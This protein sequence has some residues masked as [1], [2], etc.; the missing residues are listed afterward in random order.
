MLGSLFNT[1]DELNFAVY[2]KGEVV[3]GNAFS[4]GAEGAE[5]WGVWSAGGVF[6][7]SVLVCND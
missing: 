3:G 7:F 4:V 5:K 1:G 6:S 2:V